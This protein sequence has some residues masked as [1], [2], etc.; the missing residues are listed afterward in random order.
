[1]SLPSGFWPVVHTFGID[2]YRVISRSPLRESWQKAFWN[3]SP[4]DPNWPCFIEGVAVPKDQAPRDWFVMGGLLDHFPRTV[5]YGGPI[6]RA[7][8]PDYVKTFE[9]WAKSNGYASVSPLKRDWKSW[10]STS[11]P[12][13]RASSHSFNRQDF[14]GPTC[15]SATGPPPP[16]HGSSRS[17]AFRLMS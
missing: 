6:G 12:N 11:T 5:W 4:S 17:A 2:Q 7:W 16:F 1:M 14:P 10:D 9:N 15:L 8:A 3:D 13:D